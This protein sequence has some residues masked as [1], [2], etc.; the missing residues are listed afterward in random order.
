MTC[1]KLVHVTRLIGLLIT[2][3]VGAKVGGPPVD[4][5][6]HFTTASVITSSIICPAIADI[7]TSNTT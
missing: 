5:V 3:I 6:C 7:H 2:S 4:S 1:I